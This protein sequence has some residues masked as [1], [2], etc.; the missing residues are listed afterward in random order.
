VS[1]GLCGSIKDTL[2]ALLPL[3]EQK[4]DDS[5]LKEQLEFYAHEVKDNMQTYVNDTGKKDKIHP[6]YVAATD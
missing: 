4:T 6:E 1:I 2:K 3:V 5:F